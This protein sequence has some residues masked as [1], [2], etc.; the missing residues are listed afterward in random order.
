MLQRCEVIWLDAHAATDATWHDLDADLDQEPVV[1]V[2]RGFLLPNAKPHHIT[3][4]ASLTSDG[5]VGDITCI[6][7]GMVRVLDID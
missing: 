6:P 1:V 7:I 3:V 4:A 2:T 5:D